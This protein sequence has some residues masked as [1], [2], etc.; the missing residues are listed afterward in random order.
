M[1]SRYYDETSFCGLPVTKQDF[2]KNRKWER[3]EKYCEKPSDNIIV[4]R[5]DRIGI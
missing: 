4:N 5:Y 2:A 3:L 1:I